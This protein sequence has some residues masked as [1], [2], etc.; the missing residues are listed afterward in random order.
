MTDTT[1]MGVPIIHCSTCNLYHPEQRKHCSA[2]GMP[3]LFIN[4]DG[5]CLKCAEGKH[6]D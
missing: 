4:P 1:P 6:N 3:S 2:C 5:Y